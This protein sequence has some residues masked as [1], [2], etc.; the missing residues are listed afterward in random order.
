MTHHL[1]LVPT[2]VAMVAVGPGLEDAVFVLQSRSIFGFEDATVAS[3]LEDAV[4]GLGL[5]LEDATVGSGLEDAEA[6]YD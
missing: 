6:G 4:V 3:G 5:G 1:F 2:M